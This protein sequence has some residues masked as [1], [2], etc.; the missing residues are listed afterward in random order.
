MTANAGSIEALINRLSLSV[1]KYTIILANP[2]TTATE[3]I[4]IPVTKIR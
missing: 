1:G 2:S 3:F 4:S